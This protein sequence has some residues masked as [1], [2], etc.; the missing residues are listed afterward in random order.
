M[1]RP[2]PPCRE[3][4]SAP[5]WPTPPGAWCGPTSRTADRRVRPPVLTPRR[6]PR[7]RGASVSS[8]GGGSRCRPRRGVPPSVRLSVAFPSHTSGRSP[9]A[10]RSPPGRLSGRTVGVAAANLAIRPRDLQSPAES[11]LSFPRC[12]PSDRSCGPSSVVVNSFKS[13]RAAARSPLLIQLR[14]CN[15]ALSKGNERRD[16]G[17]RKPVFRWAVWKK[18]R[19]TPI[20]GPADANTGD[21]KRSVS[22]Q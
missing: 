2:R 9:I 15:K 16:S 17:W 3:H 20:V 1:R 18:V 7:S 22:R 21:R 4:G 5:R 6:S 11:P 13:R 8:M 19:Q 12:R 10:C 14:L